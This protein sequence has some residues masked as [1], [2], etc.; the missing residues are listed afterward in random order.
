[1]LANPTSTKPADVQ[2]R[3]AVTLRVGEFNLALQ[4]ECA[5]V[6]ARVKDFNAALASACLAITTTSPSTACKF[7]NYAVYNTSFSLTDISKVV[8]FHSSV[9]G[10]AKLAATTYSAF[11]FPSG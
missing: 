10:Q 6:S 3:A 2:R 5:E 4:Q 11:G 9:T 1:M 8:Y 7:D